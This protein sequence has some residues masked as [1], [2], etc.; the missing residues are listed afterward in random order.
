MGAIGEYMLTG[1][2][3][4]PDLEIYCREFIQLPLM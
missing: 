3:D 1:S 4:K 2:A